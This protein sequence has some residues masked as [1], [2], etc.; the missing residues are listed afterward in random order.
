MELENPIVKAF[1][2]GE[3]KAA[4][5]LAQEQTETADASAHATALAW[6]ARIHCATGD[7]YG[8]QQAAEAAHKL[9]PSPI[10]EIARTESAI[11]N[12]K[13]TLAYSVISAAWEQYQNEN[14]IVRTLLLNT[15]AMTDTARGNGEAGYGKAIRS[16]AE[17]PAGNTFLKSEAQIVL[18]HAAL[19]IGKRE[20]AEHAARD[21]H[22]TRIATQPGSPWVAETLDTLGRVKRHLQLP[23]EAVALHEAA[24]TLWQKD[25]ATFLGPRAACYHAMAQARYR[26]G[27]FHAARNDMAHAVLLTK[28]RLG[29]DHV[30]TWISRFELARY[31]IDCGDLTEGFSKMERAK[32]EVSSR[33]GP[34]HP[35][36]RSMNQ[37]I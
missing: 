9:Q 27:D 30:D 11:A 28:E 22:D 5:K 24:L 25:P 10:V 17:C 8:A 16:L 34:D 18:A 7:I 33:L 15:F 12:A 4:L 2:S 37:F 6:I 23:F 20:E 32:E 14:A 26:S 36:V 29:S 31:D 19:A 13:L 35:V 1:W 21:A 3:W